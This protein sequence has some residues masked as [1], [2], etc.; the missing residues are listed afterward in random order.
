[1]LATA[2][3][4]LSLHDAL[5]ICYDALLRDDLREDLLRTAEELLKF[6]QQDGRILVGWTNGP[7]GAGEIQATYQATQ[8]WRQAYARSADDKRSEEHTSELQSLTNLVCR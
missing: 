3:Y 2:L 1:T 7:V 8:T 4:P 6:Q 5:P